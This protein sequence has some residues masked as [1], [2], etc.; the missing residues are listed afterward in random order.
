MN[1]GKT[2]FAQLMDLRIVATAWPCRDNGIAPTSR[3]LGKRRAYARPRVHH[4]L[5]AD[6]AGAA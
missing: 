6:D 2:L 3:S 5:G 4:R 1:I